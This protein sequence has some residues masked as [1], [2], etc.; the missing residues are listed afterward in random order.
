MAFYGPVTDLE[1]VLKS[2]RCS[3]DHCHDR[4]GPLLGRCHLI[5]KPSFML[6]NNVRNDFITILWP[7]ILYR[8]HLFLLQPTAILKQILFSW[9]ASFVVLRQKEHYVLIGERLITV[10]VPPMICVGLKFSIYDR[11]RYRIQLIDLPRMAF[12]QA[13]PRIWVWWIPSPPRKSPEISMPAIAE[14]VPSL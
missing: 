3:N 6:A 9:A 13:K 8:D 14:A 2:S 11:I 1:I 5:A 7:N 12:I 10:N 4:L